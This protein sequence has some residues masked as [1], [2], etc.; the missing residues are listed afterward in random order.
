V[1][2]MLLKLK[3]EFESKKD[4][5]MKEEMKAKNAYGLIMQ[6]YTDNIENAEH[7]IKKKKTVAGRN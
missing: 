2:D 4:A 6:Q 3:D 7:E 5:L 1:V